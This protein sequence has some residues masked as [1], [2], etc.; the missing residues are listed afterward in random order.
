MNAAAGNSTEMIMRILRMRCVLF[1]PS[2]LDQVIDG[3]GSIRYSARA[4]N[5]LLTRQ[6]RYARILGAADPNHER[7]QAR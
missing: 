1:I 6:T 2:P 4:W 7:R 3:D 5:W